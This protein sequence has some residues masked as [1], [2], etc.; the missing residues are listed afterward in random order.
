VDDSATYARRWCGEGDQCIPLKLIGCKPRD[1]RLVVV[2]LATVLT[3]SLCVLVLL[4]YCLCCRR[5]SKVQR[6]LRHFKQS[7]AGMP[8]TGKMS[9]VVTDIQGY[10]G[11][12][13]KGE[14]YHIHLHGEVWLFRG[15]TQM[16]AVLLL[17]G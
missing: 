6:Q 1:N 15:S 10:S 2:T 8:R 9:I 7:L 13:V 4:T 14:C 3:V 16:L 12:R 11:A 5:V 17:C